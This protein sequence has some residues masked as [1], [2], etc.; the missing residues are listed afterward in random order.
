MRLPVV[1]L[2]T[3]APA[4]AHPG[5]GIVLDSKGNDVDMDLQQVWRLGP[6]GRARVFP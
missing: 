4:S 5:V 3:V 1:I 6:D 2:L